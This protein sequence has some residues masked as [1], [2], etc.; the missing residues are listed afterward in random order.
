ME[1]T[2]TTTLSQCERS[3]QRPRGGLE[4]RLCALCGTHFDPVRTWG[5]YCSDLCRARATRKRNERIRQDAFNRLT[6]PLPFHQALPEPEQPIESVADERK[7]LGK[8]CDRILVRLRQ[9]PATNRE[10]SGIALKYTGRLSELKQKGHSISVIKRDYKTG[11]T[12]YELQPPAQREL[13]IA[14]A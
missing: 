2:T 9:G 14:N 10:L 6:R 8:Q 5:R 11:L 12:L 3:H 7:R 4:S 13:E 1:P